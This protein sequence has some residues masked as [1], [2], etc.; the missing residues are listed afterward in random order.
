MPPRRL[1]LVL[2]TCYWM[3]PYALH[4]HVAC[5]SVQATLFVG[6]AGRVGCGGTISPGDFPL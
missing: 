2:P 5:P 3:I 4:N 6:L 1:L